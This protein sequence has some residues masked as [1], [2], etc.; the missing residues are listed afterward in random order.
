M[1]L[2]LVPQ[3]R[4]VFPSLTVHEHLAIARL[5]AIRTSDGCSSCFPGS[6]SGGI[7]AATS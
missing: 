3:G 5:D 1:H 6:R 7:T 2:G 4:R